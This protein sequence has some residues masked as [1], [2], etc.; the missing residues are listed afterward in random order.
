MPSRV[1]RTQV[2]KNPAALMAA[3]QPRA[4]G[5]EM[6]VSAVGMLVLRSSWVAPATPGRGPK[7]PAAG[8]VG[9]GPKF[10]GGQAARLVAVARCSIRACRSVMA[11][12]IQ[13]SPN[14]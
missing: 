7:V 13:R 10:A 14:R 2:T 1:V 11:L 9:T 4:P 3:S 6:N 12:L 5:Q 8:A